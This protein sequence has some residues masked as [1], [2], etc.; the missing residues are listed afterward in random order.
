MGGSDLVLSGSTSKLAD[1]AKGIVRE[2]TEKANKDESYALWSSLSDVTQLLAEAAPS[3]FLAAMRAGLTGTDPIHRNMFR[4]SP[5][6]DALFGPSSPHTHILW[7]LEILAWSPDYIDEVVRVLVALDE[8]D[9]G[10]RLNNRPRASLEGILSVW[11]PQTSGALEDRLR[12]VEIVAAQST[13]GFEILLDLIPDSHPL[14]M[15]HPAPAF[16]DWKTEGRVTNGEISDAYRAISSILLSGFQLTSM[17]AQTLIPRLRSFGKEFRTQFVERATEAASSWSVGELAAVY[18]A[19]REFV[20]HHNEFA[21]AAWALSADELAPIAKLRDQCEPADPARRHRWLFLQS[22]VTLGD[23]RKRDDYAAFEVEL[24]SRRQSA[25]NEIYSEGGLQSVT[26]FA[27]GVD[28]WLVGLA[29]GGIEA[30]VAE[31]VLLGVQAG[32]ARASLAAGFL[33][34]RLRR[35]HFDTRSLLAAHQD[36]T[37]QAFILRYV[38][39]HATAVKMLDDLDPAVADLYWKN[40]SYY[41]LGPDF[42]AA[43]EVGWHLIDIG[44]PVAAIM[45]N[46]LY[47][48]QK[49]ADDELAELLTT[50]LETLLAMDEPDPEVKV[51]DAHDLERVFEVLAEHRGTLGAQR[52]V[53]LEWQLMPISSLDSVAPSIHAELSANP[54]FFVELLAVCFRG[55]SETSDR[56]LDGGDDEQAAEGARANA[57]RAWDVL[58]GFRQV[59]GV[60][61]SGALDIETLR[62]WI[63]EARDSLAK[64]DR[65]QI[66]D[67]QIGELLSHAPRDA[68]GSPLPT[69]LR[70]LLEELANDD[71]M[72][73]IALGIFN[74]RGFTTRDLEDGGIQ[75][76]AIADRY[77]NYASAARPWPLTRTLF[78]DIAERYE[79]D[80]RREDESAERRRQ[81]R[82]L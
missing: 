7:A 63:V 42:A 8:L 39:D 58:R 26:A 18:E 41:G 44:R 73:G 22:W 11:S 69:S 61:E 34:A 49:P 2:V 80:A 77:R 29:L 53:A 59:P 51:M 76:W 38:G 79:V 72:R 27:E 13:S 12:C 75:E 62:T 3:A 45:L 33:S 47:S 70:S 21:D 74:G 64:L 52:V 81:G 19:L 54:S 24:T 14:Q 48:A 55:A 36:V 17:R 43:K 23:F 56:E 65:A 46:L 71:I 35:P 31:E 30:D 4:D 50:A 67:L 10:G 60:D 9:P 82:G 40:F 25:L 1:Y 5:Q 66:G 78:E 57:M 32:G 37:T 6:N 68:D 20:A 15:S 28:P 16:R